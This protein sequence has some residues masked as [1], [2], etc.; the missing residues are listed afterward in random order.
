MSEPKAPTSL[1]AKLAAVVEE[2]S[3]VEK[4]GRN[5]FHKYDY[6]TAEAIMRAIRGPLATRKVALIPSLLTHEERE[7]V[8]EKGKKSTL[9]TVRIRFTFA[10]G[11][12]GETHECEWAGTGD[13]PG[14]KG[15]YKAYTGAIKTFLRET[16]LLPAGDD[17]EAD[18]RTDER[19]AEGAGRS[20]SNGS[21]P[22]LPEDTRTELIRAAKAS[23][24]TTAEVRL[25]LVAQ[26]V[27]DADVPQE[28]MKSLTPEQ[29]KS[30]IDYFTPKAEATGA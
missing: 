6:A 4:D 5:D 25:A 30:L 14:D 13:D 3:G 20:K 1:F 8:S 29:A 2:V 23:G 7:S 16:F 28:A 21:Q 26:G 12:T 9:T 19:T 24:A 18:K 15:L 11:E 27:E 10:D 22:T 17:P